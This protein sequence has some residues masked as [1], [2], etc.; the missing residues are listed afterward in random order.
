M[1]LPSALFKQSP[2]D[3]VVDEIDA[4]PA[5]GDGPHTLVRF[6][7]RGL[8]TD[9]ALGRLAGKAKI[10]A[11]LEARAQAP[12]FSIAG[13]RFRVGFVAFVDAG[14]VFSDVPPMA[15]LDGPWAPFDLG[16]GGGLRLRW[17]ET[18]VLRADGAWSPT[19]ETPG[20]YVDVGQ[21]F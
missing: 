6:K 1:A 19:R 16:V 5:T 11:N 8:T 4:Y 15:E 18:F 10:L 12:G 3:F 9:V 20:F 2:E 21:V 17:G 13:E 7:K 14:R